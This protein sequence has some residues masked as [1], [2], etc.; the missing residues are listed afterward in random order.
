MVT[1]QFEHDHDGCIFLGIAFDRDLY[2]CPDSQTVIAR[3][4]DAGPDYIS[5]MAFVGTIP[6]L[7]EAHRIA[8]ARGYIPST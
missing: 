2:Y 8:T 1:P 6:A 7:T 4:S 3:M 5:G